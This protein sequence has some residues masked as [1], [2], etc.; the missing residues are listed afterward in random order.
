[1]IIGILKNDSEYVTCC[2][3]I[4]LS[5]FNLKTVNADLV[6]VLFSV[7]NRHILQK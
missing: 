6:C 3:V 7:R 1:M 5:Q 4:L 2:I